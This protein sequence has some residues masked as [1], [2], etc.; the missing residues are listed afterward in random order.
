GKV[1]RVSFEDS[2]ARLAEF[3]GQLS[4][5]LARYEAVLE[6]Q[7]L[8]M[9][10]HRAVAWLRSQLFGLEETRAGLARACETYPTHCGLRELYTTWLRGHDPE[11][12]LPQLELLLQQQPAHGWARRELALH[13]S[14]L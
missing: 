5:A 9:S 4:E 8:L 6:E 11:R 2:A 12:V 1:A 14:D 10:A 13:L 3:D 7:P